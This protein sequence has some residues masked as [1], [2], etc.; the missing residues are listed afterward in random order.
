MPASHT[1]V[2]IRGFA[3]VPETVEVAR[4]TTVTW[5]SCDTAGHTATADAEVGLQWDSSH[6]SYG[7]T[8]SRT[9]T[10]VDEIG[11][12]CTPHPDMRARLVVR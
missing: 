9:F 1:L 3:F 5:I 2:M 10:A 8:Y 12:H 7:Q 4:G 11:Y 6:L